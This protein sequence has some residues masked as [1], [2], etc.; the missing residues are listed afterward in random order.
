MRASQ[1][2]PRK[3]QLGMIKTKTKDATICL[4][5]KTP[6]RFSLQRHLCSPGRQGAPWQNRIYA[7]VSKMLP[8]KSSFDS[9]A[10]SCQ[11]A[12]CTFRF[13][14]FFDRRSNDRDCRFGDTALY[15]LNSTSIPNHY[16]AFLLPVS[17][18][19]PSSLVVRASNFSF[20][21]Y[22][23]YSL[24]YRIPRDNRANLD[25]LHHPT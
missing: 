13:S 16:P 18:N 17:V 4:I 5:S 14:H 9:V 20:G 8:F 23:L 11:A 7:S 15:N 2:S 21:E 6:F 22:S 19:V 12:D 24:S 10:F 3:A 25:G 1:V